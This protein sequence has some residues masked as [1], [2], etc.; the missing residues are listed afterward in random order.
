MSEYRSELSKYIKV[1]RQPVYK[2]PDDF[3]Y[4]LLDIYSGDLSPKDEVE[5]I[6]ERFIDEFNFP[7]IIGACR[8]YPEDIDVLI[9]ISKSVNKCIDGDMTAVIKLYFDDSS[10]AQIDLLSQVGILKSNSLAKWNNMSLADACRLRDKMERTLVRLRFN[11]EAVKEYVEENYKREEGRLA[12]SRRVLLKMK[13]ESPKEFAK[14]GI[15]EKD[16]FDTSE[17]YTIY[18]Y[19][20]YLQK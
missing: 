10:F 15:N 1:N 11:L 5:A 14:L 9:E 4:T 6:I 7:A 20:K 3:K 17:R 8:I 2:N 16:V 18:S 19:I 13:T 12:E